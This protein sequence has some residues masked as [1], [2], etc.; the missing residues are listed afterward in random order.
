METSTA[1]RGATPVV[2]ISGRLDATSAS[3]FDAELVP[4]LATPRKFI[5]LDL[6][7]LRYVSSAGLRSVLL[8]IKHTATQ[9]GR[10]LLFG[11]SPEVLEVIE[12]SGFPSMLGIYSSLEEALA[13]AA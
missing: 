8:L 13:A 5:V 1:L 2:A 7:A 12:I 11:A 3:T 9:G 6:T 10:V 4:L